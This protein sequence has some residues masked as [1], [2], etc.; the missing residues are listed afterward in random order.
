MPKS[1]RLNNEERNYLKE[2]YLQGLPLS[3]IAFS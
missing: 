3:E 1:K 2:L